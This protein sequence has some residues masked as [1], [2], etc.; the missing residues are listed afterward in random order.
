ML[1][2]WHVPIGSLFSFLFVPFWLLL[3]TVHLD[4]VVNIDLRKLYIK[5]YL[6]S[7]LII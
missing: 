3:E 6:V 4:D 7:K 1:N 2:V 5:S